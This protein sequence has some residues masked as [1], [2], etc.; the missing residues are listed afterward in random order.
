MEKETSLRTRARQLRKN[1]TKEEKHLWYDFLRTY[2]VQ[3]CAKSRLD[4]I[5]WISIAIR[6]D[7]LLNWMGPNIIWSL[8]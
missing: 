6:P 3:F 1:A 4:L 5:L 8:D 7:W 2:P